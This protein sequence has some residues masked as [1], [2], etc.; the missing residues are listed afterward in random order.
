M[1]DVNEGMFFNRLPW[2]VEHG[3]NGDRVGGS[4]PTGGPTPPSC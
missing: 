1:E 3:I 4:I 2:S